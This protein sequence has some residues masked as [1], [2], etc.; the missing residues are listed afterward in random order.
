MPVTIPA[1]RKLVILLFL[2]LVTSVALNNS[3]LLMAFLHAGGTALFVVLIVGSVLF[4]AER[5]RRC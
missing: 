5:A 1:M 3:V 2:V 4:F